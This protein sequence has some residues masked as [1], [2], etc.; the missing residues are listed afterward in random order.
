MSA[1]FLTLH[2][3]ATAQGYYDAGL[4]REHTFYDLLHQNAAARPDA[5]ALRDGRHILNWSELKRWV[6]GVATGLDGLGLAAGDRVSL[7]LGNRA[8]AV[9]TFLACARQGYVCNPS[10]HRSYTAADVAGLLKALN[11]SVLVTEPGWGADPDAPDLARTFEGLSHLRGILTPDS[12]PGPGDGPSAI[13]S[14]PDA[15]CYLAFT[16]GTTGTPKCV[17][18]SANTILANARDMV[19]D[20]GHDETVRLLSLSPLSHHIAWVA[21]GQWLITGGLLI[22]DDPPAGMSKLDW[23]IETGATYVM[24]VPTHAIDILAEQAHRGLYRLGRGSGLLYG[25]RADPAVGCGSLCR[26]GHQAAECLW[27]DRKL[28]APV[29]ASGRRHRNHR[30]KLRARR[31]SLRGSD[32]QS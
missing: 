28:V 18:H 32:I 23:L 14:N 3:P 4:W 6:D 13:A 2:D 5:P 19:S 7:W 22:T 12:F 27:H 10:L 1:T 9:V 24:G 11:T 30:R 20:W 21:A 15:V 26:A 31:A 16:S 8:E 17:M 25:R 29:H